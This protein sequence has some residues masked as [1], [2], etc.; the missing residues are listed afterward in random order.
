MRVAGS[1]LVV[2]GILSQVN[3]LICGVMFAQIEASQTRS[4][5][6]ISRRRK[7]LV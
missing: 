6:L 4:W 2:S 3:P 7:R 5:L 1:E